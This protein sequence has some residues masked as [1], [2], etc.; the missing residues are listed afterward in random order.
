MSSYAPGGPANERV[1]RMKHFLIYTNRHKDRDLVTTKRICD[2][3]K[4]KGKRTTIMADG[5]DEEP[6]GTEGTQMS[7]KDTRSLPETAQDVPTDADCMIVLGGD[8]TVLQDR[9]SVV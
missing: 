8:G 9:K 6:R 2:F 3:L 1:A 7:S 4:L 5:Q